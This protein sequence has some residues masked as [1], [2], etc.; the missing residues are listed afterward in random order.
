MGP[1]ALKLHVPPLG[2]SYSIIYEPSVHATI[3]EMGRFIQTETILEFQPVP[4]VQIGTVRQARRIFIN[5]TY[6]RGSK[7]SHHCH[8]VT[9]N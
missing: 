4:G 5:T 3:N 6:W 8:F 9:K 2:I 1:A 7:Y